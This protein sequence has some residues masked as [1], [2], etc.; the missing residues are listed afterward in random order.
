MAFESLYSQWRQVFREPMLDEFSVR[1]NWGDPTD[2]VFEDGKGVFNGVSSN[3]EYNEDTAKFWVND[4]FTFKVRFR[5]DVLWTN[6]ILL[7]KRGWTSGYAFYIRNDNTLELVF[8]ATTSS[9]RIRTAWSTVF[10]TNKVYTAYVTYDWS[11]SWSGVNLYVDGE[12]ETEVN[13]QDSM[14]GESTNSWIF[15]IGDYSWAISLPFSWA[16]DIVESYNYAWTAEQVANDY[17]NSTY[18]D[19]RDGLVLDIDS[20]Q[21]VIEDKFW[22]V[23]ENNNVQVKR[24]WVI[25][26]LYLDKTA[27]MK[28]EDQDKYSFTDWVNDKPFSICSWIRPIIEITSLKDFRIIQKSEDISWTLSIEYAF[29][30]N[31]NKELWMFVYSL[32]WF[33]ALWRQTIEQIDIDKWSFV[34]WTYDWSWLGSWIKLY[35]NTVL[36]SSNLITAWTYTKMG[37]T[38]ADLFVG[39]ATDQTRSWGF[40]NQTRIYNKELSMEEI[41]QLYTSSLNQYQ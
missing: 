1:R 14:T 8:E 18:K 17:N 41:T 23:I 11:K 5:T 10:T 27:S 35:I 20:R 28:I 16:I 30:V 22:W 24:V 25:N 31:G 33:N 37:N 36:K 21:G 32:P 34:C 38:D 12:P 39:R 9:D 7:A 29:L 13:I 4:S 6:K 26:N 19:V 40:Q 2:V 3:I 15:Q